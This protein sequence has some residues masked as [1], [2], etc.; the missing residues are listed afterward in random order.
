M[1]SV[2]L[3]DLELLTKTGASLQARL[4]PVIHRGTTWYE[5]HVEVVGSSEIG[6]LYSARNKPRR[7]KRINPAID[8][9][10][11]TLPNLTAISVQLQQP[12]KPPKPAKSAKPAKRAAKK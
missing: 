7:W 10:T 1:F 6:V 4:A 5:L 3:A 11:Q 2:R 12:A 8:F 9:V